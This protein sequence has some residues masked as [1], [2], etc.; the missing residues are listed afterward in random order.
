MRV[1]IAALLLDGLLGEPPN[2]AHPVVW[3][4][5]ALQALRHRAPKGDDERFLYG[6]AIAFGGGAAVWMLARLAVTISDRL[7]TP[8]DWLAQAWLL[9]T[10][11]SLRGLNQAAS[12]VETA[13]RADDLPKAR[14]ALSW[15]LVSRDTSALDAARVAAAA[16]ESVAENTSDGIVAPLLI[17]ALG[18]LPAALAYRYTNTGDSLLGYHDAE[19]EWLGKLPA[20]FDDLLNLLPSRLT[21][22]LFIALA[23]RAWP[24][25]RRD[26]SK[27][28]SPNAGQPMSA[29]AGALGVELEKVGYYTLNAGARLPNAE[30]IRRART[31]MF[32]ASAL[33]VLL[34][35]TLM[36][37][38]QPK[39]KNPSVIG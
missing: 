20:R 39:H 11:F 8:L 10:A 21:A 37:T 18:G 9:K 16:V 3:M 28:A 17:Y 13:L 36:E 25:W 22:L 27:T 31:L 12:E 7:P 5:S 23:P 1:L 2:R 6:G 29:M 15:H 34:L 26:G 32:G 24:V 19:R 4:G 30:D 14:R 38:R 33:L 35:I